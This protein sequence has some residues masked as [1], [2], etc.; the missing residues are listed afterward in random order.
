MLDASSTVLYVGKA[1]DLTK[2]LASYVNH[3]G[4]AHS[5]TGV[6]LKQVAKA[7]ILIT[8][9][10]KEALILEASLI[11]RHKPK[12]NVILRDDKSYPLI[13]VTVQ[14]QW[15]RVFM[16]RRK[17]QDGARYFGPYSSPAAMWSTLKLLS[18]LF[19]LRRC[20]GAVLKER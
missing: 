9:T 8:R 14:E 2:R 3:S 17:K 18:A 1:K 4:P 15:P 6:M 11:K 16:T 7:D 13:K 12:Y 10:E 19:P 20:K 5:K